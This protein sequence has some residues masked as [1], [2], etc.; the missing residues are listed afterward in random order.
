MEQQTTQQAGV[1]ADAHGY[2]D[3]LTFRGADGRHLAD[4]VRDADGVDVEQCGTDWIAEWP[5]GS[6]LYVID[7]VWDV[8]PSRDE[9]T[10]PC[11]DCGADVRACAA[12]PALDDD[13][14]WAELTREHSRGCEWVKTRSWQMIAEGE[15]A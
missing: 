1:W 6:V 8:A 4:A 10:T 2:T 13:E 14:A 11:I 12:L 7:D 3:G 9:A 5:D 15:E